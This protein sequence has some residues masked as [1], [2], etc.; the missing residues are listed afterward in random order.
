MVKIKQ[1]NGFT[2]LE[3]MIV[4]AI[5]GT[6]AAI[7]VPNFISFRERALY[8]VAIAE[9]KQIEKHVNAF[10]ITGDRYPVNL[11]EIGLGN[12]DDPWGTPYQYLDV[13]NIK[14]KG[15]NRKDRSTNPV[16]TDFDLYSMGPDRKSKLPFT[17]PVSFDDIVR[18]NDGAY[19]GRASDY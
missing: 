10:F 12:L 4:V 1:K 9:I 3:L 17:V 13:S 8:A 15:K 14:G 19:F 5:I 18:A 11:A 16:N 2:L 7:A 6:L